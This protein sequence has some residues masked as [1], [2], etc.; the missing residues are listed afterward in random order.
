MKRII[1]ALFAVITLVAVS[2]AQT[3]TFAWDAHEQAAELTGFKL[4]QAKS[5]GGPYTNVGTF[6]PGA[7]MTGTITRPGLGRYYYVLTAFT[8]EV[9]SDNS[10]EVTLVVKPKAPRLINAIQTALTAPVK[11]AKAFL[12]LFSNK[13]LKIKKG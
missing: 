8:P 3:V 2:N 6:T 13:T 9:E 4:Y 12:A 7:L 1:L 11:A 10:N 5:A